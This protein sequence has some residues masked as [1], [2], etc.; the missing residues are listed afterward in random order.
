MIENNTFSALVSHEVSV[1]TRKMRIPCLLFKAASLYEKMAEGQ[2]NCRVLMASTDYSV[3]SGYPVSVLLSF[4][5]TFGY[6][7][8]IHRVVVRIYFFKWLIYE[9]I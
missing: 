8:Y 1:L 7:Y 3:C 2:G 9:E 6:I 5:C 4:C